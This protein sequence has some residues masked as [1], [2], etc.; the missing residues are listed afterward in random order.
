MRGMDLPTKDRQAEGRFGVMF[1]KLPVL[2]PLSYDTVQAIG[3]SMAEQLGTTPAADELANSNPKIPAGFTFLGQFLDHDITLDTTPLS[4]QQ[5]DPYATTNFRTPRFDLDSVYGRGPAYDTWLYDPDDRDK[6][7]LVDLTGTDAQG[8]TITY[9]DVPRWSDG[10][11]ALTECRNDEN[12]IVLQ[13]HI[14]MMRFH[15]K[16]VDYVRT[17]NG[18]PSWTFEAARRLARWH[19]QWMVIHDFLPRMVG[20]DVLG[21]VYKESSTGG[22]PMINLN[23]YKPTNPN[24]LPFMPVEHTVAAYRFGHSMARPKYTPHN[25]YTIVPLFSDSQPD[26]R[27]NRVL[28]ADLVINWAVFFETNPEMSAP[29]DDPLGALPRHARKIDTKLSPPLFQLPAT[30]VPPGPP[31]PAVSSENRLAVRNLLR[32][33]QLGL[34]SGQAVAKLMRAPVLTNDQLGLKQFGWTGEAPL[35]Y[36]IL[37]EAEVLYAGQRLGPVGGRIVAEVFV[38]LLQRDQ[39]SYLYLNPSWRPTLPSATPGTFTMVDLLR[40][41]VAA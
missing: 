26:L 41:A 27:G 11:A 14:A 38:G 21:A 28:P 18:P 4:L 15:N 20:S 3:N 22:S 1:K 33:Q 36:Y 30:V 29:T 39:N 24:N 34:P 10:T 37:K 7:Q 5:S 17:Q 35:W 2:A 25:R 23:Y 40:Y 16:L 9:Y 6:L 13:I 12:V 19:Y 31:P 8:N 32:S